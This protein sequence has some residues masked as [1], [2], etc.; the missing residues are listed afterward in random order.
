MQAKSD[1]INR[2]FYVITNRQR[3]IHGQELS[4]SKE[5]FILWLDEQPFDE[6]FAIYLETGDKNLVPTVDRESDL[7]PLAYHF[8]NMQVLSFEE[9][10]TKRR[11]QEKL[12]IVSQNGYYNSTLYQYSMSGEFIASYKTS[13]IAALMTQGNAKGILAAT[14][15]RAHSG[16]F[17]WRKEFVE[18]LK[19]VTVLRK[20]PNKVIWE[21][22]IGEELGTFDTYK[23]A[24]D[25]SGVTSSRI[26]EVV[27]GDRRQ[28]NGYVF[29]EIK[30][31]KE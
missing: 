5:E 29:K 9:N 31:H 2:M 11:D 23:E 14:N 19:P 22:L 27:R 24:S 1:M 28:A 6:L 8:D 10:R 20:I 12:A 13:R 30:K 7:D 17:Q 16:G 25:A 4:F 3:N 21:N 18:A 15:G 26:G